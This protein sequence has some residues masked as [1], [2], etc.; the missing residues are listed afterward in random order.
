[1]TE[2]GINH[3]ITAVCISRAAESWGI[4]SIPFFNFTEGWAPFGRVTT[5][6]RVE[7][8]AN[9]RN[10][11]V[12]S[13]LSA[14]P[15]T[16]HILMVDSYYLQQ[17]SEILK[18]VNEY[19]KLAAH[20]KPPGLVLGASTWIRDKTRIIPRSHFFDGWATPEGKE[21]TLSQARSHGG[22]LP[23]KAVGACYIYPRPVWEVSGYGVFPDL[24]GGEHNWLCERSGVPVL[25]SLNEMLWHEPITYSWSKRIRMSVNLGRFKNTLAETRVRADEAR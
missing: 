2:D 20:Q 22:L 25:L 15:E 12:E 6:S 24:H 4:P 3:R 10:K 8:L 1:M 21:I 18:L 23:V 11:A 9:R 17:G 7:Y 19:E 5:I 14:Y 16:K 13:A